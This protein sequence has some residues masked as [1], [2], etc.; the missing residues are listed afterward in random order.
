MDDRDAWYVRENYYYRNVKQ[1]WVAPSSCDYNQIIVLV[2][3][4]PFTIRRWCVCVC[5]FTA[6]S[7]CNSINWLMNAEV[8]ID[9]YLFRFTSPHLASVHKSHSITASMVCNCKL[10]GSDKIA[11]RRRTW[12]F[13]SA[14]SVSIAYRT[15]ELPANPS[16]WSAFIALNH[17][18][19]LRVSDKKNT[20]DCKKYNSA[21]FCVAFHWMKRPAGTCRTH[22][23]D[24]KHVSF[25]ELFQFFSSFAFLCA[26]SSRLNECAHRKKNWLN[27]IFA[28]RIAL[29]RYICHEPATMV[30]TT[31]WEGEVQEAKTLIETGFAAPFLRMQFLFLFLFESGSRG[32]WTCVWYNN[33]RR[34]DKH[35][36][37]HEY[38]MC[39][40][41]VPFIRPFVRF[42]S[43]ALA[44]CI[45]RIDLPRRS[46]MHTVACRKRS[47][48][49]CGTNGVSTDLFF[50]I[51]CKLL[52]IGGVTR[53]GWPT[54]RVHIVHGSIGYR[55]THM[56]QLFRWIQFKLIFEELISTIPMTL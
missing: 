10:N 5:I 32:A 2:V 45:I 28:R 4:A 12:Q 9:F 1:R 50:H 14:K 29:Q 6:M 42:V 47:R 41:F 13:S 27:R 25:G 3:F 48:H 49:S 54:G 8:G 15:Q 40:C 34:N 11:I 46:H 51:K 39:F 38:A 18:V 35:T 26:P 17:C 22:C 16:C 33:N 37:L 20:H 56:R 44:F 7:I 24:V 43:R 55:P 31:W 21:S 36:F 52:I 53:A 19:R 23:A 30:K